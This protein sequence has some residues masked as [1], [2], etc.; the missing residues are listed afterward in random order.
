MRKNTPDNPELLELIR[1]LEAPKSSPIYQAMAYEL[2][3]PKRKRVSVNL[4]RLSMLVKEGETVIVPG[5]VLSA[6]TIDKKIT[7]AAFAFSAV[8]K[9]MIT[10]AGGKILTIPQLVEK[11]PKGTG[12]CII[13]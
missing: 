3:K 11:N 2:A 6:G 13:K 9:E 12:V 4:G 7:I 10:K 1:T 8:A 5:K